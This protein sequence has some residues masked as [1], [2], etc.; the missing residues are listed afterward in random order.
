[1]ALDKETMMKVLQGIDP[2]AV[3]M[4]KGFELFAQAIYALGVA[5]ER[6]KNARLVD[7][8]LKEGGGT[9]GDAIRKGDP[10]P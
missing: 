9:Y 10:Q 1:M 6:E 7:H 8:I 2:E 5:D 3:R 4:P